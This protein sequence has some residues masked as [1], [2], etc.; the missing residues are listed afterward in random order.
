V[1][2][3]PVQDGQLEHPPVPVAEPVRP[4]SD[5]SRVLVAL[6]LPKSPITAAAG[7]LTAGAVFVTL[8]R[9]FSR[10]RVPRARGRRRK[11][12]QREV[13]ASRSFLV[14]VHMLGR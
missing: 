14:D 7:G 11:T 10:R 4:V 1:S 12:L 6:P 2:S 3:E 5:R 9:V 8:I 13:V